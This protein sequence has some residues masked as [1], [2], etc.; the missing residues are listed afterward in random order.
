MKRVTFNICG[1]M[2]VPDGWEERAKREAD[3]TST[4]FVTPNNQVIS[5]I[6]ALRIQDNS[7][8]IHV[9]GDKFGNFGLDKPEYEYRDFTV[10]PN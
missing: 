6:I 5:P 1:T 10:H 4:Y 3:T 8:I 7:S 9:V 2:E